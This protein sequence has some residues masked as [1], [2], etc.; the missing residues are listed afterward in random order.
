[1]NSF[2][3][4]LSKGQFFKKIFTIALQIL[5]VLIMLVGLV[6]WVQIWT[7]IF[8]LSPGGIVGGFLFQ[9]AFFI[10]IYM[11]AHTILIRATTISKIADSEYT[12][13]HVT[14]IFIKL[15]GEVY[16][17]YGAVIAVGGGLFRFFDYAHAQSI[18]NDVSRFMPNFK[19]ESVFSVPFY[20]V[21]GLLIAFF[22]LVIFYLI[23]EGMSLFVDIAEQTTALRIMQEEKM[24]KEKP[25]EDYE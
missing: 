20:L 17:W 7:N 18:L 6:Y 16:A 8:T 13:L 15:I 12:V 11:I 19:E 5:S 3:H 1:M 14:A 22:V 25:R 4:A 9:I 21:S 23:S 2:V 24:K 10:G